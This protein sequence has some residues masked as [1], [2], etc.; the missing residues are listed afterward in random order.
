MN[1]T[2]LYPEQVRVEGFDLRVTLSSQEEQPS[3]EDARE[4]PGQGVGWAVQALQAG[5]RVA[6]KGWNGKD[7]YLYLASVFP[8]PTATPF[9]SMYTAQKT[10]VPW[11]CSQSNFPT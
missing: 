6:C 8:H 7:M 10:S 11:T 5:K 1:A 9:V 2:I 4:V 3:A